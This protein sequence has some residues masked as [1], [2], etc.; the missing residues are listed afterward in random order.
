MRMKT[1]R[2]AIKITVLII[3]LLLLCSCTQAGNPYDVSKSD[4]TQYLASF[5]AMDYDAMF[6]LCAPAVEIKKDAFVKKYGDIFS[7]LGV[8]EIAIDNVQGPDENGTFT[9]TATYKTES[10]GDFTNDFTIR[11]GFKDDKCVVLWDYSLIF[12]DMEE[13]STVR[14]KTLSASRGEMFGADGELIAQNSFADTVY[15]DI[16]KVQDITAVYNAVSSLTGVTQSE[17]VDMFNKAVKNGTQ[18]IPLGAYFHDQISEQQRQSI[19]AVPG[20][21]IDDKMYTPMR[22]YP[23]KDAAAQIAGYTGLVDPKNVPE[24]YRDTDK[25]GKAGLEAAFEEQLR[26]RK[27]TRLNSSHT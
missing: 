4:I 15:M 10:Y 20:L 9:Y 25:I 17:L 24:G 8:K 26:D 13:G 21:G 14:I 5:K 3:I 19:L 7:G 18:A 23:L 11:T 27:S 2:G 16:A 1:M 22:N 6:S 12:P